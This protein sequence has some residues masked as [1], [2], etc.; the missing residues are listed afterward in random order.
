[1]RFGSQLTPPVYLTIQRGGSSIR[2]DAVAVRLQA[3]SKISRMLR[4]P[5]DDLVAVLDGEVVEEFVE[6]AECVVVAA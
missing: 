3:V 2:V 5:L 4:D 6:G 1:M